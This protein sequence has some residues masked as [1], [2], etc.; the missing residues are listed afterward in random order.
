MNIVERIV[1]IVS[2]QAALR[3]EMARNALISE[4]AYGAA[5]KSGSWGGWSPVNQTV[6]QEIK[7]SSEIVR[8]R[9]RQLVRDFP[10]FHRAVQVLES[11]I[12]GPNGPVVQSHAPDKDKRDEIEDAWKRWCENCDISGRMSWAE[13]YQLSVRQECECG[14]WI[15]IVRHDKDGLKLQPVEPDRLSNLAS[16]QTIDQGIEFDPQTGAPLYYH[17]DQ[18]EYHTRPIRVPA[19]HV[20]HGFHVLRPG[21]LRGISPFTAGV[22]LADSLRGYVQSE[23]E[24]AR[25]ASRYL[26]FIETSD[27]AE[28]QTSRGITEDTTN[29]KYTDTLDELVMEYLHPGEKVNLA[30]HN[31]PGDAFTPFTAFVLKMLAVS[32]GV[33]YEL[34][35]GD[36]SG[37]NYST[38]RVARND[39][40]AILRPIQ[41][42][43]IRQLANPVWRRWMDSEVEARR[44]DLPR[45]LLTRESWHDAR[46]TS[47]GLESIDP[48][49]ESK[50]WEQMLKLN[51]VSPQ[52]LAAQR[53]RAVEAIYEENAEA[54][55]LRKFY[56]LPEPEQGKIVSSKTN[57]A[58]ITEDDEDE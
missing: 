37:V 55:E 8:A 49:K 3:R 53:G 17:I 40:A 23:T 13:L 43:F 48:L 4:R 21:Q 46:W 39:L 38:M 34:L 51:L 15:F 22:L 9:V 19:S 25:M 10:A 54:A 24:A 27:I 58:A 14:E 26:A 12:A 41:G 47:P 16:G 29:K 11:Y 5:K 20:L 33:P 28:F 2:P 57:P 42:R 44:L 31:R 6:N 50:A 36:Y 56:G 18:G 7:D 32:T 52:E 1:G 30:S 35:S 45:Y